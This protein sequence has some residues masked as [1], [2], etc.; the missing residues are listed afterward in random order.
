MYIPFSGKETPTKAN[1]MLA[2]LHA[3]L[4]NL[5]FLENVIFWLRAACQRRVTEKRFNKKIFKTSNGPQFLQD[6]DK[7]VWLHGVLYSVESDRRRETGC[8][9]WETGDRKLERV[10]WRHIW[11]FSSFRLLEKLADVTE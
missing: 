4:V 1:F 8:E 6:N 7:N 5:E 11:K 10:L 9:R 3:V 2:K